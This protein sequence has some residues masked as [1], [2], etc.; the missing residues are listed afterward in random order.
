MDAGVSARGHPLR[1]VTAGAPGRV[2]LLGEHTD[3]SGGRV[4]PVAINRTTLVRARSR[5][6]GRIR[7]FSESISESPSNPLE[8]PADRKPAPVKAGWANYVL[9]V[10][11]QLWDRADLAGGVELDISGDVPLG[12]G[13]SSSASL[14]V[15]C[16]RALN[17]LYDCGL[18]PLEIAK[19]CRAA[20]REFARVQCGIMDQA[21]AA[22]S[23]PG[24]AL[25]LDCATLE[26]RSVLLP[27]VAILVAHS[28]IRHALAE[29]AY[30]ER[31][32]ECEEILRHAKP[33]KSLADLKPADLE[34]LGPALSETLGRRA[35]HVVLENDRV[36][37]GVRA[38]ES[39]EIAAF[40]N[41]MFESHESLRDLYEVSCPELDRIVEA[42]RPVSFG[43]KMTG[44]GF[45]GA[46]V[47]LVDP[48]RT[49]EAVSALP[50]SLQHWILAPVQPSRRASG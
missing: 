20:E 44:A 45:G 9:G 28:G 11:A 48:A 50:G 40:G 36:R 3:Y 32:A 37:R 46:V 21:A 4:L 2:N 17:E 13:L 22:L 12:A 34:T 33:A 30:N 18:S 43:A 31:V 14:T 29:T 8:H 49:R 1:K 23:V 6:D 10:M 7:I 47:A 26:H 25:F 42:L 35:T 41:L 27:K 15:A 39:G 16:A 19:A 24:H 38:L 5:S